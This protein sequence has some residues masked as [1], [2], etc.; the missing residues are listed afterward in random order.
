MNK[1]MKIFYALGIIYNLWPL[2]LL[3]THTW[4]YALAAYGLMQVLKTCIFVIRAGGASGPMGVSYGW[5]IL[6]YL[7]TRNSKKIYHEM[8]EFWLYMEKMET[9][10]KV[11]LSEQGYI[12]DDIIT[13]ECF[14]SL[15][16]ERLSEWCKNAIDERYEKEMKEIR[17]MEEVNKWDGAVDQVSR[18]DKKLGDIGV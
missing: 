18:R 2:A 15:S 12:I 10:Y 5:P 7:E 3:L 9:Q 13:S 8:G 11:V 1:K 17:M 14:Y 16:P 6:R 4:T